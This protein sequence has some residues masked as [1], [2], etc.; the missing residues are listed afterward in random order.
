MQMRKSASR[1]IPKLLRLWAGLGLG[2]GLGLGFGFELGSGLGLRLGSDGVVSK[3]MIKLHLRGRAGVTR[4][5]ISLWIE[6]GYGPCFGRS[7]YN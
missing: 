2:L 3:L 1:A 4:V 7:C 5:K 6:L